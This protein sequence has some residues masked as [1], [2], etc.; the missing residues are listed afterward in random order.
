M[1]PLIM[2]MIDQHAEEA[3][4]LALLRDQAMR[5]P[6]YDLDDVGKLDERIEA[7]LDGLR[8]A[9][10]PGLDAVLQQLSPHAQGEVFAATVPAFETGNIAAMATLAEQVRTREGSERFMAAAL[11]WLDWERVSPWIE[12][13]LAS[14]E[15]LFRRLGLAACGMHRRDPGSALLAGLSHADP[16]VLARAARTAGELRRRDLMSAIRAHRQHQDAATRFWANWATAQMGDE[17]ALEPLRQFAEQPGEFQ[18]RALCVWLAWQKREH[19]IA[20]IRQLMQNPGQRR[21]GIQAVGLL[22]DPVSVP[23]LIQQMSDLPYARVAGEAFSLMTGADLALLDLE[24]QDLPDFDAGPNDDPEDANVAMDPDENL[25]WPDPKLIAAWW[26]AH[27]GDFQ[28][29]VGYVLGLRQ[30]E[31]SY[32]QALI[33]GQQRQRIAAACGIARLRPTEVLFPTSAPAW[34]QKALLGEPAAFGR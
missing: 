24:L 11:G 30:N 12:R 21:I 17:E 10:L 22:G 23:W 9:G 27:A 31:S 28:A 8:I 34:R 13:M 6:H 5:A 2:N 29:G 26:Q 19:S 7:H 14:P 25:P 3:G 15:P 20:W 32:W 16:G 33:Q 1:M 18:Y 4:F